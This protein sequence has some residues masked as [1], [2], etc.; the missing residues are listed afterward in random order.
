MKKLVSLVACLALIMGMAG[1][2]SG[3]QGKAADPL[4]IEPA[5]QKTI[6]VVEKFRDEPLNYKL[7]DYKDIAR[8]Y[9][10][11][12][13]DLDTPVGDM[14]PAGHWLT[15]TN[16]LNVKQSFALL[17]Y[18]GHPLYGTSFSDG[19]ATIGSVLGSTLA[20]VD[21]SN[22]NGEAGTNW[23]YLLQDFYNSR[24]GAR[25]L[26]NNIGAGTTQSFW[27]DLIPTLLYFAVAEH[28]EGI[29]SQET[30]LR[31]L[32]DTWC[33]AAEA[34][35]GSADSPGF[36]WSSYDTLSKKPVY[37]NRG[38]R[39]PDGAGGAALV[40]WYAYKLFGDEKYLQAAKQCMD[41]L[42]ALDYNPTY[43]GLT[44]YLPA[45]AARMNVEAGTDYHLERMINWSFELDA[46][47]RTNWGVL[48]DTWG[49]YDAA[50]LVGSSY[51]HGGY[52]FAMNTYLNASNIL[53]IARYYPSYADAIGKYLL[54][55]AANSRLFYEGELPDGQSQHGGA[56]HTEN[57][58]VAYEAVRKSYNGITPYQKADPTSGLWE[59]ASR[60][61][62]GLYG[63]GM[64]G[65]MAAMVDST[66]VE[67]ILKLDCRAT[68]FYG[69]DGY[70]TYLLYNPY[71]EEKTV[72]IDVGEEQVDL[73]DAVSNKLLTK[74]ASGEAAVAIPAKGSRLLVYLPAGAKLTLEE[75]GNLYADGKFINHLSPTLC[76][77]EGLQQDDV[78]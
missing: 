39:E 50:G 59:N 24:T 5:G 17:P 70:P 62:Y 2:S 14:L 76:F 9:Q 16:L 72:H 4:S 11:M 67:K 74:K 3:C 66:D 48:W 1:I 25:T 40:N 31:G 19:I 73:Y 71:G 35:V 60:Y 61:D 58:P 15:P 57:M 43:E 54:N 18:L 56:P 28:Y 23:V 52:G 41:W 22:Q 51:I 36:E 10:E 53:P 77:T 64:V 45:A 26:T 69:A 65:M 78:I 30:V 32:A 55:V 29:R 33:D 37:N 42:E 6:R 8:R 21:M 49:E 12:V 75:N 47:Y 20:G 46:T 13:F 38:F 34:L 68:D 44:T 27:N 7:I 63:G